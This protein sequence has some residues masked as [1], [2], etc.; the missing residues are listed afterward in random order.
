[1]IKKFACI[2]L[3]V[4][5]TLSLFAN[6]QS[7]KRVKIGVSFADFATERWPREA[8]MM[9]ALA[10]E[11]GAEL[12]YQVANHD[13]K[14]QNDQIENMILQGVNVL[15]IIPQD[16]LAAVTAVESAAEA[17]VKTIAYDRLIPTDKL[18]AYLT[19]DNIEIGRAQA[20]G[21]LK[22]KD[23]GRFMLLGGSPD[24]NCAV[25]VRQGQLEILQPLIDKGRIQVVVD[26]WVTNWDP[27]KAT[28]IMENSLTAQRNRI[29]AV[30]ASNDGTALGALQAL[31]AQGLGGKVPISGQDATAAGSQSIVD[32]GL[33]MTVYN[34]VRK[35]APMAVE[36]AI[37]L[38]KGGPSLS[39]LQKFTMLELTLDK[40]YAN[41]GSINCF[42]VPIVEV[43]KS[44]VYEEIVVSGYQPYDEVYRNV[45]VSKRPPRP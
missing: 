25:L 3:V 37:D 5:F 31:Q 1:M 22:V 19:F 38:V 17:G 6:G 9:E 8:E 7:E 44:N 41:S 26:Q 43:D 35:L 10:K 30:V 14:L 29:D 11:H 21:I 36:L 40:A 20:R 45:P 34:D 23:S 18:S 28:E 15:I 2:F 27:A 32:G 42:F 39:K 12:I 13:V 4:M 16:G 33:T 24:D